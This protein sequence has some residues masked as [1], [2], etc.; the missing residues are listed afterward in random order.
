MNTSIFKKFVTLFTMATLAAGLFGAAPAVFAKGKKMKKI[1][2]TSTA[3]RNGGDIPAKYAY[4]GFDIPDAQNLSIPLAWK[5]TKK[6]AKKTKS[7]AVIMIDRHPIAEKFVH[8]LAYNIPASARSLEEGALSGAHYGDMTKAPPGTLVGI[9]TGGNAGYMGPYPPPNE[10]K[11]V[12]DITVYALNAEK[13]ELEALTQISEAAFK[14]LL[15]KKI[16]AQGKLKGKFGYTTTGVDDAMNDSTAMPKTVEIMAAGFYPSSVTISAGQE[17]KFVNKDAQTHWP[18]SDSHPTHT[19]YP[20]SGGCISSAF[21]ACKALAQD[22]E[23]EFIFTQTGTWNYHDHL[24]P[25]LTGTV[26][27]E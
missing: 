13:L 26:V 12:Y 4:N 27:V 8:L 6:V 24:N 25:S 1:S 9:T 11:H 19:V 17:V 22:E 23:W 16:V 14:K 3:F 15:K 21:D 2:A 5:V 7:F 20:Q 18:A 10:G